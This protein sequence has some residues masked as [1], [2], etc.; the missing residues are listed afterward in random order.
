VGQPEIAEDI[1]QQ[2]FVYLWENRDR[3]HG[4]QSI[5][6][7]MYKAVK[8]KSLSYLKADSARQFSENKELPSQEHSKSD[9][10]GQEPLELDLLFRRTVKNLPARCRAVFLMKRE[11]GMSHKQI[12]EFLNIS[13]KTV[14]YHMNTA[15]TR[16][17]QALEIYLF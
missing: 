8:N 11:Y 17:S 1:V 3:L 7:Y 13:Q 12:A 5:G 4:I 14:E 6:S 9:F 10:E 2:Q 15:I 16:L